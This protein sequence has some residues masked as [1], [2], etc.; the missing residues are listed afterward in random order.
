MAVVSKILPILHVGEE[1]GKGGTTKSD[2]SGKFNSASVPAVVGDNEVDRPPATVGATAVS[3]MNPEG[4]PE[5]TSSDSADCEG[6][7]TTT[8][9]PAR[10]AYFTTGVMPSASDDAND[11]KEVVRT[12]KPIAAT[13]VTGKCDQSTG[14]GGDDT[15][16]VRI[17]TWEEQA[18]GESC[19]AE[20]TGGEGTDLPP[21]RCAERLNESGA[22]ESWGSRTTSAVKNG[23]LTKRE[24][25]AELGRARSARK[26]SRKT[27]KRSVSA[28]SRGSGGG[29]N[30][31]G[32]GGAGEEMEPPANTP[33]L[34]VPIARFLPSHAQYVA[35]SGTCTRSLYFPL[36]LLQRCLM[37]RLFVRSGFEADPIPQKT[38]GLGGRTMI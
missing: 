14:V 19:V 33:H 27:S 16:D 25:R 4:S 5:G 13:I 11:L 30:I 34:Q 15:G 28:V 7:R 20:V 3:F 6:D 31:V 17:E 12:E 10:D 38:G 8:E 29:G 21:Q 18:N 22:R 2:P 36:C 9:T 24:S 1:P 26:V 37:P 23:R 32:S 35:R